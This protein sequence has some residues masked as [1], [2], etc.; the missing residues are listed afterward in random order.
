MFDATQG[1]RRW[2]LFAATLASL[3]LGAGWLAGPFGPVRQGAPTDAAMLEQV[4]RLDLA[5]EGPR[6]VFLGSSTFLALDLAAVTP[7]ALN[8][9][10]GGETMAEMLDRAAGYRSLAVATALFVNSG[11]NDLARSC[12]PPAAATLRRLGT[13]VPTRTPV[14]IVGVQLP[15]ASRQAA[16]CNSRIGALVGAL[17]EALAGQCVQLPNCVFIPNPSAAPMSDPERERLFAPD[18]IH[19]S[20]FGYARL[21]QSLRHQ[22]LVRQP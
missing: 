20:A 21:A 19:F 2:V 18:G 22:L 8:L 3:A 4:L 15:S 12:Q 17:N 10:V 11:F 5:S 14:F 16:M 9:S 7:A 1:P 13:L 6:V